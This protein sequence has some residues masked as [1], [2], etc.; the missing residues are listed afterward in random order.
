MYAYPPPTATTATMAATT[1][2]VDDRPDEG[3]CPP[4]WD[5][6]VSRA[7]AFAEDFLPIGRYFTPKPRDVFRGPQDRLTLRSSAAAGR[8]LSRRRRGKDGLLAARR[9]S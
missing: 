8:R 4:S 2:A 7:P 5:D 3:G 6:E 9:V 1:R